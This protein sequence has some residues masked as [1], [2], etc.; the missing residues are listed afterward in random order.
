MPPANAGEIRRLVSIAS[1]FATRGAGVAAQLVANT[2]LGNVL[3]ADGVG[4]YYLY[5]S[6]SNVLA[7]LQGL[8]LPALTLRTVAMGEP[9][10][11][12]A[13]RR[14]VRTALRI[15]LYSS[16]AVGALLVLG[17]R[18]VA[19]RLLPDVD[20]AFI[21]AFAALTALLFLRTRIQT[22]ALKACNRREA[23]IALENTILPGL[24]AAGV[25][26]AALAGLGLS[27]EGAIQI[28]V[29]AAC[30]VMLVAHL[31]W[32]RVSRDGA[33]S[34]APAAQPERLEPRTVLPVWGSTLLTALMANLPFI[35]LPHV[36]G[37]ADIGRFAIAARLVAFATVILQTLSSY[38]APRFARARA[39]GDLQGLARE[40]RASQLYSMAS[41]LPLLI[42]FALFP[43]P[44]LALFGTEFPAARGLLRI[45]AVGQAVN[46]ATGLVGPFLIMVGRERIL[47]AAQL[48]VVCGTAAAMLACGSAY[49]VTGAAW[50]YAVGLA[51]LN[52]AL[53]IE[54]RRCL[55]RASTEAARR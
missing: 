46:A 29:V 30:A 27:A 23:A 17:V 21:V 16:A 34:A 9:P 44:I 53:L 8:G 5:V 45:L 7:A 41:Y 13:S 26:T 35:V 37:A 20:S 52:L 40:L 3:G 1:V 38:F 33:S 14:F 31:L 25:G 43:D 24:L 4:R 10:H 11:G 12:T 28:H 36:A 51:A 6:W 19:A 15:G 22:A 48:C 54:A 32:S 49:S 2:L 55:R 39:R 50:A 47:F 18:P 42:G